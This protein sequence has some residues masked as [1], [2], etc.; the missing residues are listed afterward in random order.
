MINVRGQP[1]R[2]WETP[3]IGDDLEIARA[4]A[5]GLG[6][7]LAAP[8]P[9]IWG[10]GGTKMSP[11]Q[12]AMMREQGQAMSRSDYSPVGH[13]TQGLGRVLDGVEGGM[14][15][16]RAD[17]MAEENSARDAQLAEA[18]TTGAVDDA[19]IARVLMDPSAG[20]GVRRFAEMEYER[21]NAPAK[22][23]APTP[24][25]KMM[26]ARGITPG[27]DQWNQMLDAAL[28]NETDPFVTFQGPSIGYTG[29]QSGLAAAMGGGG[30][31]S[32]V[33][34][35]TAPP[36]EAIAELQRD[37]SE[38]ARREF[39]EAFGQGAAARVMGGPTLPASGGFR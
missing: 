37:P 16:K 14:M 7:P 27:S 36:A 18:M 39:D 31:P 6:E 11:E 25:E 21:R 22:E 19:T 26:L 2:S 24:I 35:T 12:V 34:Q 23:V 20:Q 8:E 3:G 5:P 10:E 17:R 28:L 32:G 9:F 38:A 29:R 15:V 33:P 1:R 13:W 4:L 30:Q